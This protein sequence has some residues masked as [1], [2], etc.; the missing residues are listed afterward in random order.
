M[1]IE[2]TEG[3]KIELDTKVYNPY[4]VRAYAGVKECDHDFN[5]TP[6]RD[7]DDFIQYKCTRCGRLV[8]YE[9]YD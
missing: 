2:Q 1:E 7:E 4:T 9:V 6:W 5:P 8:T 3:R